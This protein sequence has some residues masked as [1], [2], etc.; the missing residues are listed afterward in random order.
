MVT[1]PQKTGSFMAA[2]GKCI[3]LEGTGVESLALL[4]Q[5]KLDIFL[6]PF[7]T[8]GQK[9]KEE[10]IKKSY[11]LFGLDG[12]LFL[13]AADIFNNC[14]VSL[15][16]IA[17]EDCSLYHYPVLTSNQVW[18][19]VDSQKDYGTYI[20]NSICILI[21]NSVGTL[22]KIKMFNESLRSV[23]NNLSFF[24]WEVKS[25]YDLEMNP[26]A[27]FICGLKEEYE[28]SSKEINSIVPLFDP[29]ALEQT[30]A[31]HTDDESDPAA[32]KEGL[33][34]NYYSHICAINQ[35]TKKSFFN[36]D[37]FITAY[38]C[39]DAAECLASLI[40]Q[41]KAEFSKTE[42]YISRLYTDKGECLFSLFARALSE[43]ASRHRDITPVLQALDYIVVRMGSA[44]SYFNNEYRHKLD[45]DTDYMECALSN[46]RNSVDKASDSAGI[47]GEGFR[48]K[49]SLDDG[50]L[51]GLTDGIIPDE[52]KGSL[53]KILDYAAIPAQNAEIFLNGIKA[54]KN[55]PDKDS[56]D[57]YARSV[58]SSVVPAFFEIYEAVSKKMFRQNDNSR[59]LNMFI[60][61]GYMDEELLTAEQILTLYRLAGK[62]GSTGKYPVYTMKDWL[63]NI[64]G[65]KADPS[66]N[67]FGR[68]YFDVFRDMK[69]SFKVADE[70]KRVYEND[71][72][73][74]LSF[75]IKNMIKVNHRICHG[76]TSLY[77]PVLHKEMITRDL[78]TWQ[79]TSSKIEQS[80]DEVL[81]IDFSAFCREV[82]Y[83]NPDIGIEKELIM[84]EVYPDIILMPIFGSRPVM[85]QEIAGRNRSSP[86]RFLIPAFSGEDLNDMMIRLV[87]YFRWE[88]CR[89]MMGGAWNDVTQSSLTSD[90]TDYIQFYKKNKDLSDEAR[91]RVK[92]QIAKYNNRTREIFHS[93]YELW[94]NN[95]AKGNIRLNK[96]A[97]GILYRHCPFNSEIR[98]MLEK[99]PMYADIA[100][101][102]R[103]QRAKLAKEH[104][105]RYSRY[106]KRNG[107][108]EPEL[109]RTLAFYRNM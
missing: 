14:N 93:D 68:D 41:L 7:G 96:V 88:L 105:S 5:G 38:N 86:G 73:G 3:F 32:V 54:F 80:L 55:L 71:V 27:G 44:V 103:N 83:N 37:V 1:F 63:F 107:S 15:T 69:K 10:T 51:A 79:V 90:Y 26:K 12:N 23:T 66:I 100:A 42:D 81:K 46:L 108:L 2:K 11:R 34:A 4:L 31:A 20:L 22:Q 59:L 40:N 67:E 61:F 106:I 82:N 58:R 70:D 56:T 9:E 101:P 84:K 99:Q 94:I 76:Q 6:S 43:T 52:L 29:I 19:L 25:R 30:S 64:Y 53:Y 91:E 39:R 74:R 57:E 33:K 35:D 36:S 21:S 72:D 75:E 77:F 78:D 62:E 47:S 24:F 109:E 17:S 49:A 92:A 97:R 65:K 89:T 95:E 50:S 8:E 16:C 85:W 28:A 98:E 13:G 87:A 18:S 45:V 48:S 60:N 102:F 104:A